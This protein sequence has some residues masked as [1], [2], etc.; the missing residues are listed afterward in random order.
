MT[1]QLKPCPFCGDTPEQ[2]NTLHIKCENR[3][4][5]IFNMSVHISEWNRRAIPEEYKYVDEEIE[6]MQEDVAG[7]TPRDYFAATALTQI[8]WETPTG[9]SANEAA[10]FAYEL[11]DA[12]MKARDETSKPIDK[13]AR[14]GMFA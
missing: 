7:M 1:K 11:A 5:P 3:A 12:M 6:T 13:N 8:T 10:R 9:L 2:G 4:C 14:P